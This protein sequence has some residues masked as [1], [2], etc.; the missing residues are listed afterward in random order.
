MILTPMVDDQWMVELTEPEVERMFDRFDPM[1]ERMPSHLHHIG[2][3]YIKQ[4]VYDW[5][6]ANVG[7]AGHS[8]LFQSGSRKTGFIQGKDKALLF[9]LTWGG[10]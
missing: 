7:H 1:D 3:R 10:G 8:W 6:A 2:H 5:L 9:K 4:D